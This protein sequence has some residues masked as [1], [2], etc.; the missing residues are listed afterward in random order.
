MP[1]TLDLGCDRGA[2]A[3]PIGIGLDR[4]PGLLKP[5]AVDE[6]LLEVLADQ[7]V[8]R[9]NQRRDQRPISFCKLQ[10][11]PSGVLQVLKRLDVADRDAGAMRHGVAQT[12]RGRNQSRNGREPSVNHGDDRMVLRRHPVIV[13][14]ARPERLRDQKVDLFSRCRDRVIA[15]LNFGD[16]RRVGANLTGGRQL[17]QGLPVGAVGRRAVLG[18]GAQDLAWNGPDL[19]QTEMGETALRSPLLCPGEQ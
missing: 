16:Q 1:H 9:R 17:P 19:V 12:L 11:G 4:L 3:R 7:R 10:H 14:R 15:L 5:S 13:A 8:G 2:G 6:Q 18:D